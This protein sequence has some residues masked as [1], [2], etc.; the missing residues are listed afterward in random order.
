MLS[1]FVKTAVE[2]ALLDLWEQ[3]VTIRAARTL[4]GGDI[5]RVYLLETSQQQLVIKLNSAHAFPGMFE[6]EKKGLELLA[7]ANA[8]RIPTAL[9]TGSASSEA[10]LLLEYL[11]PSEQQPDFWKTFGRSLAQLHRTTNSHFGLNHDNY[12]GSLPQQNGLHT[13]WTEYYALQRLEPQTRL[14]RNIGWCSA[15]LASQ[16]ERLFHKIDGLFPAE[17]PA[18]LHGDLWSGNFLVGPN[19]EPCLIDP[20]AYFGHREMELAMTRLFGG[21]QT[22]FYDH[23]NDCYPLE[24]EWEQRLPI[25]QLYPILVHANLFGGGYTQQVQSIVQ[26]FV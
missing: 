21:F 7:S 20:A 3:P 13:S 22:A 18:L 19:S 10:F 12:I 9:S 11:P 14:G 26:R 1:P 17:P 15:R 6:A 24:N 8:I 4:A 2:S 25:A 23:Y 16:M 5:N